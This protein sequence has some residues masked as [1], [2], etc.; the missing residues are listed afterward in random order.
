LGLV[1]LALLAATPAV[2]SEAVTI[3]TYRQGFGSGTFS[4]S[5]AFSDSGT[6]TVLSARG[7]QQ[8]VVATE[9][10]VGDLGTFTIKRR[11]KVMPTADPNVRAVEGTWVV[12]DGT[13]AYAGLEGQGT[14]T[15][16]IVGD[17][18]TEEFFFTY[19]GEA[20]LD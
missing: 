6:F 7:S 10:Y 18:P 12:V 19:T 13:G 15:G 5:G 4:A 11:I 14:V 2:A 17:G 1:V 9:R 8:V 20:D 3:E 16:E